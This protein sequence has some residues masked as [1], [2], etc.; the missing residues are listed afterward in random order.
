MVCGQ[1]FDGKYR[2]L[3]V[4]GQG[5]MSRVYLAENIKLGTLWAVKEINKRDNPGASVFIE[6]NILKKLNHPALPRV[7][8]IIEDRS[9]IYVIVDYIEGTSLDKKLKE[10]GRFSET[11]VLNWARQIC[12]VLNYLH[13]QKPN[14]VIYRDM[15][16]SNLIVTEKGDIKLIDFGIA[17]EYKTG[18]DSDTIYI[19]TRG[20]AAPEQYGAGQTSVASDIYSLGVTLYHLVTGKSPN[21]P[22]YEIKPD[23]LYEKNISAEFENIIAKCTRLNPL[24]RYQSVNELL[25]DINGIGASENPSSPE[26][27]Q[28]PCAAGKPQGNPANFK[29]LV[30]TVWDNG[31]FGCELAYTTAKLTRLTVLLMD[32]DLL[33]P[34]ADLFLKTPKTQDNMAAEGIVH[35]T[36]LNIVMDAITRSRF[37]PDLLSEASIKRRELKNLYILTGNYKLENY[38]YFRDES[39]YSLIEKAY[40]HFDITILLVNR[41][42]YDLFTVISLARADYN[43]VALRADI[44]KLREFNAYLSLLKDKQNIPLNKTKF[45]AYEYNPEFNLKKAVLDSLTGNNFLGGIRHSGKRAVYRNLKILYPRRMEKAVLADYTGILSKFGIVPKKTVIEAI[46]GRMGNV[47][48]GVRRA[49]KRFIRRKGRKR[50]DY[51]GSKYASQ[52]CDE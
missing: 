9:F 20:Y 37:S 42:I 28:N 8:D 16:P 24:E 50:G 33:N 13:A 15:K 19:G 17:R 4:L 23:R 34:T 32:L 5:G 45:V 38:E 43:I 12:D 11:V 1:L 22:P 36:G 25:E 14:P 52:T 51:A 30:L 47:S 44:D 18:S 35:N 27:L 39:L 7:F 46:L 21:T 41:S 48:A 31:E 3:K 49:V 26:V 6:P 40:Q 2:I 29:K 10:E